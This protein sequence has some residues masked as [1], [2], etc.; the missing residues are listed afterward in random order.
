MGAYISQK[1]G[2]TSGE[3]GNG[4]A[5]FA[6]EIWHAIADNDNETCESIRSYELTPEVYVATHPLNPWLILKPVAWDQSEDNPRLFT[7]TLRWDKEPISQKEKD[8]KDYPNPL[9][10]PA[11]ITWKTQ[12]EMEAAQFDSEGAAILNSAG[13]I[14]DPPVERPRSHL[15]AVVKKFVAG[16]PDWAWDMIDCAN[17]SPFLIDGRLVPTGRACLN[18]I[19][20]GE[21]QNEGQDPDNPGDDIRYREVVFEIAIKRPR[22]VRT[23]EELEPVESSDDIP[24][25]WQLEVVDQGLHELEFITNKRK[26]I[27]DDSSPKQPVAQPVLL[28][29]S[30]QKLS[31]PG[32]YDAIYR[33][34]DKFRETADFSLLPL[35]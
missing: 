21:W 16:F 23:N 11:V 18:N 13:D 12:Q 5:G 25:P 10:R 3:H 24:D 20:L 14:F 30:G 1:V 15:V 4:P 19:E 33:R 26:R 28:N 32:P 2:A 27:L 22:K 6:E 9:N 31:T 34:F 35:S 17:S 7:A 8:K 29:G